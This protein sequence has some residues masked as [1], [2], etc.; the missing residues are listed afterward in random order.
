MR[1]YSGVRKTCNTA[2]VHSNSARNTDQHWNVELVRSQED[3]E[4][5]WLGIEKQL[6]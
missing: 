5:K 3:I 6:G 4:S 2:P 1:C